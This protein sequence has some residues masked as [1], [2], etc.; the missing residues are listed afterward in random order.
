M[1]RKTIVA[2][3]FGG[4]DGG[5]LPR[6]IPVKRLIPGI[7]TKMQLPVTAPDGSPMGYS[8]DWKEGNC[9]LDDEKSLEEQ[10]VKEGDHLIVCPEI[11]QPVRKESLVG[12]ADGYWVYENWT[13]PHVMIHRSTCSD[14][15]DGRGKQSQRKAGTWLWHGRFTLPAEAMEFAQNHTH[16]KSRSKNKINFHRCVN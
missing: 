8:L 4:E 14:C 5:K 7:I 11:V 6:G 1:A 9:H 10:G 15:K 13:E 12:G 16:T 2:I 3:S